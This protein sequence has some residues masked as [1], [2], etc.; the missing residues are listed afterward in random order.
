MG[1]IGSGGWY[2][3]N[4][5]S[6]VEESLEVSVFAF[7]KWLV[8]HMVGTLTWKWTSGRS[9]S[10]AEYSVTPDGDGL[11]VTLYYRR[12]GDDVRIPI[13]LQTTPTQFGG[14]RWWFT[15]PL[16]VNGVPCNRRAGKL[17]LPPRGTVLR[18]SQLPQSDLCE[19]PRGPSNR[20]DARISR[21]Y[22]SRPRVQP[23]M[24]AQV[25]RRPARLGGG[26]RPAAR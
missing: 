5:K 9:S 7:L 10:S 17:Y 4:K 23:A 18:L 16:A 24:S 12:Y 6:T 22:L 20:K 1:G 13:R 11:I 14:R 19:L 3:W 8:P 15:C 21:P 2:R 25:S 26:E